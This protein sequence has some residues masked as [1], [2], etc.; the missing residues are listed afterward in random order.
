MR[1]GFRSW[2]SYLSLKSLWSNYLDLHSSISDFFELGEERITCPGYLSQALL[3]SSTLLR[4]TIA[5]T[6][7]P[8]PEIPAPSAP[9]RRASRAGCGSSPRTDAHAKPFSVMASQG[10]FSYASL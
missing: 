3:T 9:A 6:A 10:C 7:G 1:V 8:F 4:G 5:A 2:R